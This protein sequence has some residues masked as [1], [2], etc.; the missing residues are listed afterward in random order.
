MTIETM[1]NKLL[2]LIVLAALF[3]PA[4]MKA[5]SV[6]LK[7]DSVT[8]QCHAV[9][10][11]LIPVRLFNFNNV[12]GLQFTQA[13]NPAHL[14]YAYITDINPAFSGI[15]FDTTSFI[16]Q[17]K[18]TFSWTT[19]GGLTL[20]DTTIL[21][22]I[23]FARIGGPAT[24]VEFSDSPTAIAAIDPMG[25]DL[26]VATVPGQINPVDT[27]PPT[28][29]CPG[30][31]SM[32]VFGPTAVNGIAPASLLDNCSLENIGWSATGAT[33]A[34]FPNDPDASGAVFNIGQSTVTY[35]ATD[36][37]G[38]TASCSFLVDLQLAPSDSLT[39][40][41][42]NG[43]ASCSQT[44]T[45]NITALNFDSISGLQFSLGWDTAVL[46][47]SSV[48]NFN[49]S[50]VLNA[51]NF[52]TTQTGNGYL[53]FAWTSSLS[54]GTS[55]SNGSVL[56]SI[57]FNVAATGNSN[58]GIVFGSFP[59]DL[60]AFS[61]A[62]LP[63]EEIGFITVNGLAT[64]ADTE[65]PSIQC[66]A[67][68]SVMAPIGSI[69]APVSGLEPLSLSDNCGGSV[70]QTYQQ[71]GATTGQGAG[72]ANGTYN[73]GTTNV[74]YT[75]TDAAGNTATCAFTVTIDA[76]TP[77]TLILDTV[78][79]D[80]QANGGK[81]AVNLSVQDFVD[82][83]GLQFNVSWDTAVLKF[84]SVGNQYPG[85]NLSPTMFFNYTS[86]QNG[87]PLQ[88]FGG[89]AGGWP[90]LPN[91]SVFFTIYFTVLNA[92]AFSNINFT[93]TIDAV[94]TGFNSVPVNLINGYFESTDLTPPVVTCP[95][96]TLAMAMGNECNANV[97]IDTAQATDACSGIMSI[98]PDKTDDVYPSG[99]TIVTFT[100]VDLAGNS[101]TC[102]M[103][104]TVQDSLP[105]QLSN[106]PADTV[107]AAPN[108]GCQ[109][110]VSWAAPE[111]FDP[112]TSTVP[113]LIASDSSGTV[114]PLGDSVVV[115]TAIDIFGDSAT[116]SF[117]VTVRDTVA[118]N[119]LCP[120][121]FQV[122]STDTTC[123][124]VVDYS[125]PMAFDNC[126]QTLELVN[127][128]SLYL[129]GDTFPAGTTVVT[130]MA[131]DDY[132]NTASCSFAV[133]V[134]DLNPPVLDTC[135]ANI[136][137]V[138]L[139]DTCGAF[140]TWTPP[141]AT[142]DCTQDVSIT[143]TY[144]PGAFFPVGTTVVEYEAQDNGANSATCSFTVTVTE[145][146]PPVISNCPLGFV[147]EMPSDKCD[148]LVTWTPP[149]ATD[150]CALDTLI[151]STNP[152]TVFPTGVHTVTY[153]A[154]DN[155]GNSTECSFLI[156]V[157]DNEPPVFTSCPD[158]IT[159]SP[160]SPCGEIVDWIFPMA[161]DNCQL[162]TITAT[163]Q[164][165]DLIKDQVT[166]VVIRAVDASGN[167]DTCAFTITLDVVIIPPAFDS[168]PADITINGC[169]Q[170]VNW[171]VPV[172][173]AGF[174]DDPLIVAIPDTA[175]PGDTFPVGT[176]Q[177]VY[178][179]LDPVTLQ[180]VLRDTF[181]ITIVE[182]VPPVI[183]C[184]SGDVLV[185][186][187]GVILSDPGEFINTIDTVSSCDAVLLTFSTPT[188]TDNCSTP[189]VVQ[190]TGQLSGMLFAADSV[191]TLTFI[192]TDAAG[193]TADCVIHIEVQS[194]Q[195]LTPL[196]DPLVACPGDD[197]IVMVDAFPGAVYTWTGPNQSYPMTSQIT[198]I[199]S[200][201][202]AGTYTVFADING[203]L[204]PV[205]SAEVM[206]ASNP[207]AM[208]DVG[209]MV[210]PGQSID[211]IN[212][213]LND[214]FSPPSDFT[215]SFDSLPAGVS[216]LGN[217]IF[218]FEGGTQPG[219]ISF[220]YELC[221]NSCPDFCDMATVTIRVKNTDCTLIPNIITPNGDGVNDYFTIPCLES[222]LFRNNSIVIYNQWGDKV[223]EA[224]PYGNDPLT[225]WNGTLNGE[226]GKDLPDGV[227]FYI[228]KPGPNDPPQ[229][230]FVQINR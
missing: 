115:Y 172:A 150:N 85:L 203:C 185:H 5:Q 133:T 19:I 96:D 217:G 29:V 135:P 1:R 53:G 181:T 153:T 131:T 146:V 221:S 118:P 75:A 12:A 36:V 86:P 148:T 107:V 139:P 14:D 191:H 134:A 218:S 8:V 110:K 47:Y 106:C 144:S 225:A 93:G 89:N 196:V 216:Y 227:Y 48:G 39:I 3:V 104:V 50:L 112:C 11:F 156:A 78:A 22:K 16:N 120:D 71:S 145:T 63:P 9:D 169:P 208:D 124:A 33:A 13:W 192:A 212:V 138:A 32:E 187:G 114:F 119:I 80:C 23:A 215:V 116:C 193:N 59:T 157:N 99:A 60:V 10:T 79:T 95:A 109:A 129:P 174:C 149:T 165:T 154:Y 160:A 82:I 68:V 132:G 151:A 74:V 143:S 171:T 177:I 66:P 7:A 46:S 200:P 164:P 28:I 67:N 163:K 136:S 65:P 113:M 207:S 72:P 202:N 186:V 30:N 92:N 91:D 204:T 64:I 214:V 101:A 27:E 56:F 54:N 195:P 35:L 230:G 117:T 4:A 70:S 123:S 159:V 103:T 21:F 126:D 229:N 52:G 211:S 176:S 173:G 201:A 81:V 105:P 26:M 38:N 206:L 90:Q 167:A 182:D 6:L 170:A 223:F 83:I 49:P 73:A 168:F 108:P 37:G 190:S 127:M 210:D 161:T 158:D 24:L 226:T 18:F 61:S 98:T 142:D 2:I 40:I 137:L 179:A 183:A 51:G 31:V 34:N 180:P 25:N 224:A 84:D 219:T 77:L 87:G 122:F 17:G 55:L 222:E 228:F 45:I 213:L 58:T 199:A 125:V 41:A 189:D 194:L 152:G 147:F 88:F 184:P 76:G 102:S 111:A 209:Y 121:N 94:N 69:S 141:G 175:M 166:N 57:T 155:S 20:P 197:V 100:A 178:L 198:V 188:A 130:Y 97:T 220:F 44:V 140:A 15:G 42:S 205:S 162:D 128:D 62:T 43:A